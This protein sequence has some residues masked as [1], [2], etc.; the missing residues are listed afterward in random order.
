MIS[1]SRSRSASIT[2]S[3]DAGQMN[4]PHSA[5]WGFKSSQFLTH[6]LHRSP[7][8]SSSPRN[9]KIKP[10]NPA[11][12]R[13]RNGFASA[14]ALLPSIRRSCRTDPVISIRSANRSVPG[15]TAGTPRL[16]YRQFYSHL[17]N[18]A[19]FW[20]YPAEHPVLHPE[21]NKMSRKSKLIE[22]GDLK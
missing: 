14:A 22:Q 8:G 20:N 19:K 3:W 21:D 7:C 11:R 17:M 5:I 10:L 16:L 12:H 4:I 6:F 18:I 9:R 13:A 1:Q 2:G 15:K